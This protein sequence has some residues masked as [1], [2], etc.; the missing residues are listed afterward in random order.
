MIRHESSDRY[1]P[2]AVLVYLRSRPTLVALH[3]QCVGPTIEFK[4]R[5]PLLG[6]MRFQL[7]RDS[8]QAPVF[9]PE[10]VKSVQENTTA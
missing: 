10:L 3:W 1:T 9:F 7:P 6:I 8:L 4:Q 5:R 2:H